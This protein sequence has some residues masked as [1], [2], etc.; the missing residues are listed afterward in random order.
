MVGG[1]C[2]TLYGWWRR[3]S[4]VASDGELA[5]VG[6]QGVPTGRRRPGLLFAPLRERFHGRGPGVLCFVL[7]RALRARPPL[8]RVARVRRH[9]QSDP[10]RN[11]HRRRRDLSSAHMPPSE[12]SVKSTLPYPK[13]LTLTAT[14]T[15]G[16]LVP[17]G[18]EVDAWRLGRHGQPWLIPA[19]SPP[20]T[21]A[22]A[23]SKS[24][25]PTRIP[26]RTS[27]SARRVVL[28]M[29][30]HA[31]HPTTAASGRWQAQPGV[32]C[33]PCTCSSFGGGRRWRRSR[34]PCR[35]S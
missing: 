19:A 9:V 16:R 20:I 1:G 21:P 27:T 31:E 5:R 28:R 29:R 10:C 32:A 26:C 33:S 2:T 17:P 35:C 12:S 8:A 15:R 3:G 7:A 24:A 23:L 22:K 30:M 11:S 13:Q 14:L 4:E 34:S 25:R 6:T 18:A